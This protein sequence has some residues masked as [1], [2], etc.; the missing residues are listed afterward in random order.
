MTTLSL[1][2]VPLIDIGS[3]PQRGADGATESVALAIASACKNTGFFYVANHGVQKQTIA[4]VFEAN[5]RFHA[6]PDE[7]K[8]KLRLN[9]WHRGYQSLGGSKLNSSARFKAARHPNQLESFFVR[10]EVDPGHAD[11]ENKP[12]QGPN[13]WPEDPW[14]VA[15][16]R[17]YDAAVL[18]LGMRLL[19]AFSLALGQDADFFSRRFAPASTA[20]RLIHYPPT[21]AD[22]PEDLYGANEHTDYGFMTLLV[23]DSIGGLQVQFS[24]GSW[25]AV[26]YIPDTYVVNIGDMLSRWT[27]GYF[28]STPHRVLNASTQRDRYSVAY[29]FDPDL[30]TMISGLPNL[31][32]PASQVRFDP[33]R[34]VDYVSMRLDANYQDRQVKAPD[35]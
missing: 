13:Q 27:N 22:R 15:A 25:V 10:H 4:D 29:F 28:H 16:V 17:K 23:Q 33:I 30:D 20:L 35:S 34:L 7:D 26:P 3:L 31:A 24:D 32:D 14:F 21:P 6:R 2:T 9:R 18:D 11:Y 5:K 1:D 8:L 19:P 12:L